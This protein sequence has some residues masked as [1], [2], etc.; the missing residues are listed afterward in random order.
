MT[1]IHMYNMIN[2]F[3]MML[4]VCVCVCVCVGSQSAGKFS[5]NPRGQ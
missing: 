3:K 4:C 5:E 1:I 2:T